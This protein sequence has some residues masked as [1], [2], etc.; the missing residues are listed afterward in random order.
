MKGIQAVA[1][2]LKA[3]GVEYLSCFPVNPLI[4]ASIEAGITPIMTRSERVAV[5]IADGYTRVSNGRPGIACAVQSNAG[6]ENSF[7]GVAQ[8][9]ADSTPILMLP[10]GNE[11]RGLSAWPNFEAALNYERVTKWA[12]QINFA[13]RVPEMMRR[14]FT[15]LQM[16]RPGPV[17]LEIPADVATEEIGPAALEYRP[18]APARSCAEPTAVKEAMRALLGAKQPIIHAGQGVLYAGAWDELRDLAELLHI[19]VMTTMNGKSAFPE[20]HPLALGFGG[21]KGTKMAGRFLADADLILGIGCSFG[22]TLLAAPIPPGKVIIHATVDE[23]DIHKDCAADYVLIGDAKLVLRQLID[24][25]KAQASSSRL[26]AGQEVAGAIRALRDEWMSEWM[27]RLT[28]DE[29]PINP[30]RVIWDMMQT[31]D[32]A[33][34]IV[35]H[36]SGH[37]R[38][39]LSPF[40]VST[41]PRGYLGW[42][43]TTQLGHSLGLIMGARLAAP[44]KIAINVMGDGAFGMVGADFETAAR[45]RIPILTIMLNNSVLCGYEKHMPLAVERMNLKCLSGEYAR[46]AEALGGYAERIESPAEI[47]PAIER[48]LKATAGGRPALIEFIT[49]EETALSAY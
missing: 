17:L 48:G 6:I 31:I 22:K 43:H 27:P 45:N 41:T 10:L 46:V 18:V 1:S 13:D 39:Q 40:Y 34:A 47:A 3:E 20:N 26:A 30:Y 9:Y 8:A 2:I 37:P 38:D 36:D 12:A 33:Q 21:R 28:S 29:T 16:G 4:D 11:R 15:C 5:N 23:L 35:T 14:A 24:E 49:K 7:A 19:P 42:G 32:P 25:A 44:D